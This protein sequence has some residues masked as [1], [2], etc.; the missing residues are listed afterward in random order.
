MILDMCQKS[1]YLYV[2]NKTWVCASKPLISVFQKQKSIDSS[3]KSTY[4]F[5]LRNLTCSNIW[6]DISA[7]ICNIRPKYTR[8]TTGK[9]WKLCKMLKGDLS[10]IR[11]LSSR[12]RT[13]GFHFVSYLYTEMLS[14]KKLSWGELCQIQD[15]RG[16]TSRDFQ[17]S[18]SR[19]IHKK[20]GNL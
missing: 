11:G 6:N 20:L 13:S 16:S 3:S 14:L 4:G 18:I 15:F 17:N 8:E 9:E 12:Y 5:Q 19:W 10:H 2:M 1:L 7:K